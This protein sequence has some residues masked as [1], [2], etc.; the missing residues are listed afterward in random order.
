[1]SVAERQDALEVVSD[2]DQLDTQEDDSSEAQAQEQATQPDPEVTTQDRQQQ[3][4]DPATPVAA[5]E[6]ET[7]AQ[8]IARLQAENAELQRKMEAREWSSEGRYRAEVK[9]NE[10]L[11]ERLKS[12]ETERKSSDDLL[13]DMA[14][15]RIA[16]FMQAGDQTNAQNVRLGLEAELA[17]RELAREREDRAVAQRHAEEL[18]QA[19]VQNERMQA[20]RQVQAAFIPTMQAEAMAAA[21]HFGLDESETQDLVA[22]ATPRSLRAL[23]P[24]APPEVLGQMAMEQYQAIVERA[25]Q[26][27]ARRVKS[28][29]EN[30]DTTRETAGGGASR[31][32]DKEFADADFFDGLDLISA[33]YQ[34]PQKGKRR[35]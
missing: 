25:Q 34:P 14:E 19:Q 12:V 32:L 17:K 35:R 22:F 5:A 4:A 7:P 15:R 26:Y 30:Y 3:Q 23:A 28:N 27:Q 10:Q 21:Q 9:K 8:Y 13:T 24:N 20:G 1:M 18:Q 31:D 2:W 16:Q 33:G 11:A 29:Q 6:Q